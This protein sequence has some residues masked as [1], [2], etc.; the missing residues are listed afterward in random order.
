M[1][2]KFLIFTR[3]SANFFLKN[4]QN[5]ISR[6]NS[7]WRGW[8][9]MGWIT[10]RKEHWLTTRNMNIILRKLRMEQS[11]G[12]ARSSRRDTRGGLF[13]APLPTFFRMNQ[14]TIMLTILPFE[15]ST[16]CNSTFC[17]FYFLIVLPFVILPFVILPFLILPFVLE[18]FELPFWLKET[19]KIHTKRFFKFPS[20]I[21]SI[22][23]VYNL[24][25]IRI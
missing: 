17:L 15:R 9:T 3:K 16:F 14:S 20:N 22:L 21:Y 13:H 8:S 12:D 4:S 18:P 7:A 1:S 2:R 6:L 23:Y 24:I 5:C 10:R 11:S 19:E 25:T